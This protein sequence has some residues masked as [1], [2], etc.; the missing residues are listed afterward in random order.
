[1]DLIGTIQQCSHKGVH[2]I[3]VSQHTIE[4]NCNFLF[5]EKIINSA[6]LELLKKKVINE[7]PFV[8]D[9]NMYNNAE[10]YL[11]H[12]V[13]NSYFSKEFIE[14]SMLST[15][16]NE[17]LLALLFVMTKNLNINISLDTTGVSQNIIEY[18][19]SY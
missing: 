1:M 11:L 10:E 19:K 6:K 5:D 8:C 17:S 13:D 9:K 3:I 4:G 15:N 16:E 18:L 2:F 7:L 12:A 14:L